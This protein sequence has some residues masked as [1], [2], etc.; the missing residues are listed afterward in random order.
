MAAKRSKI[1]VFMSTQDTVD[2]HHRLFRTCL[3]EDDDEDDKLLHRLHGE[4]PQKVETIIFS[5][6]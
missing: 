6:L 1:L 5:Y 4:M 3:L 2:F